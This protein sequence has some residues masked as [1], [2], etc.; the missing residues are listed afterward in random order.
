MSEDTVLFTMGDWQWNAAL[1][2]FINIVGE[3]N[4]IISEDTVRFYVEVL[5]GFE[6]KYFE[7]LIRTYEKTLSW[8]RI[9]AYRD[10]ILSYEENDFDNFDL[11]SLKGLNNYIKGKDNIKGIKYYLESA[12]YLAAYGLIESELD[13]QTIIKELVGI[14][15]PKSQVE[16]EK[17]K[18]EILDKVRHTFG[19]LRR[20]IDYCDSPSGRRYIRAKNVIYSVIKNAWNGVC[21][22]NPQT[23]EKDV[24]TDYKTDFVDAAVNYIKGDKDK[25]RFQCFTCDAPVKNMNNSMSFLIGTGF[26]ANKKSSHVWN[27]E[28]DVALCPMCKMIYSCL[29]AGMTYVGA[30]GLYVNANIDLQDAL[31]INNKIKRE[32]LQS[33]ESHSAYYAL[34]SALYENET[35]ATKYQFVDV[36]VIRYE[37]TK[38][39]FN[40][41]SRK[42]LKII[43]EHEKHLNSLVKTVFI[44][45]KLTFRIFDEVIDRIFNSQNL[46]TL[47][48]K[49][50]HYKL[51]NPSKCYFNGTHVR[52]L[53]TINQDIYH[54]L[55]GM[56]M[57]TK[58]YYLVKN[59]RN[60]GESLR[61]KYFVKNATNKL[62][63]IC[64]RLLNALKTSNTGMFMDVVLNCYLY[65]KDQVPK[66]MT[67]ALGQEKEFSTM[68]YAFVAGLIEG[69]N[70][71]E[72]NAEN[73][74]KGEGK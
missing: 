45:N 14:K 43:M 73:A 36:Q 41:L 10:K 48:H 74:D 9:V 12:S 42:M 30:Q 58:N 64:Y 40:I 21:F 44:E 28:N 66:V 72:N 37:N 24:F 26:D 22:L 34:V 47:I 59:A 1:T 2:G 15:E 53:L 55:G 35:K 11:L 8:S 25:Y 20:I 63:G 54:S 49:M 23:K 65:V 70:V 50:L 52:H 16:F 60:A 27:F 67:D 71:K 38:Y 6:E 69:D 5:D 46:F 13:I 33:G 7:Y 17:G 31:N 19:I 62:P 18:L 51:S 4:V 68:G 57:D 3:D 56:D 39:H 32:I 61:V 29:P